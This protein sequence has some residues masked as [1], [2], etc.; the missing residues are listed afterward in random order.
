MGHRDA[1]ERDAARRQAA[2]PGHGHLQ[3]VRPG[4]ADDDAV[5]DGHRK[6]SSSMTA[7]WRSWSSASTGAP[8]GGRRDGTWLDV[9]LGGVRSSTTARVWWAVRLGSPSISLRR[10]MATVTF[11]GA[12][13]TYAALDHPAVDHL[14]LEI[15]DGEFLVLVG[16]SGCGKSTTLRMLAGLEPVDEGTIHIG[17]RDVTDV[18]AE[19]P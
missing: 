9:V 8:N 11:A 15:A 1:D 16:P 5:I 10:A 17:D 18:P 12:T 4:G 13:R 19:G 14:D 2:P 6:R 3:R 7:R